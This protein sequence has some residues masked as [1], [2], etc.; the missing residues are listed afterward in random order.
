VNVGG[1]CHIGDG[2]IGAIGQHAEQN[3]SL[4]Q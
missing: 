1:V 4:G 3:M 2:A